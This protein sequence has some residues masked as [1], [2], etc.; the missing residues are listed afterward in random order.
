MPS[1]ADWVLPSSAVDVVVL[2]R[3]VDAVST[4]SRAADDGAFGWLKTVAATTDAALGG[5]GL[6]LRSVTG[7]DALSFCVAGVTTAGTAAVDGGVGETLDAGFS[8]GKS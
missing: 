7:A 2:G 8:S 6:G 1:V 3:V 4:L 5:A